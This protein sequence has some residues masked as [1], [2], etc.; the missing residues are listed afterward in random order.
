MP[1]FELV[2]ATEAHAI[3]IAKHL[4]PQSLKD[5]SVLG[6]DPLAQSIYNF[7]T[8]VCVFA[9]LL[10]G[11]CFCLFGVY[12][13]S[14]ISNRG[15]PWLLTSA[16]LPVARLALARGSRE[17]FPW[18]VNRFASLHG[19]VYEENAVSI[20]WLRWLGCT[21]APEP[22]PLGETGKLYHHFEWIA[23]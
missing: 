7:Q 12:P 10:D 14:L 4:S 6:R 9:G 20:R 19:W 15:Q 13:D 5:C 1:A 16:D 17:Y 8:S 22:T 3:A 11:R 2:P 23:P 21:I 18:L